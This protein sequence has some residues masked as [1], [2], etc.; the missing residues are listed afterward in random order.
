MRGNDEQPEVVF[1]Y[2]K[3]ED[4]IAADHPLR[5]IRPMVEAAFEELWGHFEAL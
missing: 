5:R 1:S 3:L 4:R 2:S